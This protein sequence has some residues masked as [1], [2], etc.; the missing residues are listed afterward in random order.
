M[1]EIDR[2]AFRLFFQLFLDNPLPKAHAFGQREEFLRM[3][4]HLL[5]FASLFAGI[6]IA[7]VAATALSDLAALQGTWQGHAT[8]GDTESLW[9]LVVSNKSLVLRS[10]DTNVWYETTFVLHEDTKPK[11]LLATITGCPD[12]KYIGK[13]G[14]A[15]Y[16]IEGPT[17]TMAGYEPGKTNFPSG[18]DDPDALVVTFK[19]QP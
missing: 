8:S 17:L 15:I 6:V 13:V 9:S 10:S 3:K 12:P 2:L 14:N 5:H 19:K 16:K 1:A 11:Q 4:N 7:G 18:F